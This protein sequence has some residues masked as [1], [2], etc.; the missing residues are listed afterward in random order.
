MLFPQ[1]PAKVGF[2]LVS[3]DLIFPLNFFKEMTLDVGLAL[4]QL[5]F[6]TC[7]HSFIFPG[8]S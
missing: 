3:V 6:L 4:D 7:Y 1:D 2:N 8:I 5:T